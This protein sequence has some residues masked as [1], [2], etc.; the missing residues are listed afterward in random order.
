MKRINRYSLIG[1]VFILTLITWESYSQSFEGEIIYRTTVEL[2]ED[3]NIPTEE[4]KMM[5]QDVDTLSILFL[6]SKNY[7][8]I[9]LDNKTKK[10]KTVTQYDSDSNMNYSYMAGQ[11][12]FC[13]K[14]NAKFDTEPKISINFNDTIM[15]MGHKCHSITIDYGQISKSTIYFSDDYILNTE[16]YKDNAVGFLEYIYRTRSL[17]LKIIM[18]GNGALHNLVY[19]AVEV[20]RETLKDSEFKIPQF[21]QL[22]NYPF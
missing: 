11:D 7:K 15:I 17:P 9:T 8:L 22:M 19:T 14:G 4:F 21:K 10:P 13:M 12:E 3:S 5:F 16:L 2:P 20:K 6:K 18:S 1:I